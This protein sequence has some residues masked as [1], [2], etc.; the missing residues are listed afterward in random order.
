M[1]GSGNNTYLVAGKRGSAAL[2]DAG[3]GEPR[4][5]ADLDAELRA[6]HARL[7]CVLI[8]HGHRDHVGGAPA[9]ATAYPEAIFIKRPWSG[10]DAQYPLPWRSV[11]DGEV[12]RAGDA[13]LKVVQ[14]P[15]HSPDPLALLHEASGQIFCGVLVPPRS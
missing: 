2:I 3:V 14:T 7:D 6:R 9:L 5:L 15:G 1:T 11:S 10:E 4:H 8:T 13:E 12:V